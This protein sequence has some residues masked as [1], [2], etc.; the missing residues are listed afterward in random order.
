[1]KNKEKITSMTAYDYTSA[2]ILDSV[3]IDMLLVG[4]SLGMVMQGQSDTLPVTVDEM[5]YHTKMVKRGISQAFL[6]VDLPFGSCDTV[7]DGVRNAVRI[8]KETG[9]DAVKLESADEV[10]LEIVR[11]LRLRGVNSIGHIG[12]QPQYVNTMGGYK[13]NKYSDVERIKAEAI[14]LEK[15]G[16]M[17]VVLEGMV[18]ECAAEVTKAVSIPTIGI[19]AGVECDGQVLVFHDAFGLY[20]DMLPKFVKR[21]ANLK[22]IVAAAAT[23]YINE[24]KAS[25]FPNDDYSYK[26]K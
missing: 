14:A 21:Y 20:S 18:S 4:D 13:I 8:I 11:K 19:G 25:T 12:L 9:A 23:E 22:E 15:A 26:S 5:I 6:V 16:A 7:D 17:M 24:V 2:K 1:M 10:I 3:G